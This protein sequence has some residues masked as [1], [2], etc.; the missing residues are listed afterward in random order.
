MKKFRSVL[1]QRCNLKWCLSRCE[2]LTPPKIHFFLKN[3]MFCI[4]EVSRARPLKLTRAKF[5]APNL[6]FLG[7]N[8]AHFCSKIPFLHLRKCTFSAVS[9]QGVQVNTPESEAVVKAKTEWIQVHGAPL[10][11]KESDG[12][13]PGAFVYMDLRKT[14]DYMVWSLS[15]ACE[16]CVYLQCLSWPGTYIGYF[17]VAV[18]AGFHRGL[19]ELSSW[20]KAACWWRQLF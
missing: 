20:L 6:Q 15:Y 14:G 9:S 3:Y 8:V 4:L 18:P 10:N 11:P 7:R 5:L 13:K 16:K 19:F 17:A 12:L 1:R 2:H